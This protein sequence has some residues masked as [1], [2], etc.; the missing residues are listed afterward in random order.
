[1][2]L[3]IPVINKWVLDSLT[4]RVRLASLKDLIHSPLFETIKVEEKVLRILK[5]IFFFEI[6]SMD[7]VPI[8]LYYVYS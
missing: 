8:I 1:M 6:P 5:T 4:W 2:S 7:R 3:L